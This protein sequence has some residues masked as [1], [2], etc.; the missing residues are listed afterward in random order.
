[1][2]ED[3]LREAIFEIFRRAYRESDPPGDIDEMMRTGEAK[4]DRFYM[5]YYLP[6]ERLTEIYDQVCKERKIN[7]WDKKRMRMEVYLGGSPSS[8]RNEI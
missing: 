2:R 1:M 4:R 6:I 5:N 7:K 8:T 3:K